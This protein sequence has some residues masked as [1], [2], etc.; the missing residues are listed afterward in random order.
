MWGAAAAAP[1]LARRARPTAAASAAA[2]SAS[3][4][5]P[6]PPPGPGLPPPGP[7]RPSPSP[8]PRP[9]RAPARA[10]PGWRARAAPRGGTRPAGCSAASRRRRGCAPCWARCRTGC[11]TL[12]VF[13]CASP[14]LFLCFWMS[15]RPPSLLFCSLVFSVPSWLCLLC[16][17][18]RHLSS[19]LDEAEALHHVAMMRQNL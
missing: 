15:R 1:C 14:G 11:W 18:P 17:P 9:R 12:R 16:A 4:S 2:G 6:P 5:P 19:R 7:G 8:A 3:A 13:G 10:W